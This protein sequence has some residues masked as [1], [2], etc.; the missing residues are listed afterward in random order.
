M[1]VMGGEEVSCAGPSHGI[2]V[3]MVINRCHDGAGNEM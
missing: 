2:M 3:M 1:V